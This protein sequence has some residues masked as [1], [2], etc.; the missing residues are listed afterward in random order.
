[1]HIRKFFTLL[2]AALS[3]QGISAAHYAFQDTALPDSVRVE[4]LLKELTLDEKVVLLS[5]DLSVPRLG[6]P[7]CWQVEGL[8][9]LSLSGPGK[10]KPDTIPTTIFPQARNRLHVRQWQNLWYC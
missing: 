6:I 1:M 5:T 7:H 9:G 4:C 8:H 3:F 10:E 2:F